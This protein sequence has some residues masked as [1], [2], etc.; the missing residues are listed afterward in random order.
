[1]PREMRLNRRPCRLGCSSTVRAEPARWQA[2]SGP[3][4]SLP[5]RVAEAL[6]GDDG[7]DGRTE[8][9]L[10]GGLCVDSDGLEALQGGHADRLEREVGTDQRA[11]ASRGRHHVGIDG[12]GLARASGERAN[13][14][15]RKR[16]TRRGSVRDLPAHS[17]LWQFGRVQRLTELRAG[18][19]FAGDFRVIRPLAEGGMGVVYV[20]EQLSTGSQRALKLMQRELVQSPQLRERFEREAQLPA[21]I[22]SEHVVKVLGAGVDDSTGLPWFIMELLEGETLDDRV[23]RDPQLSRAELLTIFE[24][25]C[26]ALNAAHREG[27]VHRD[28]KPENVFLAT[29]HGVG[30]AHVAKILDFGIARVVAAAATTSTG[31][32]GTPIYMAPEQ[33]QGRGIRPQTD[34][35]ALGLML[36]YAFTRRTFWRGDESGEHSAASLMYET[37]HAQLPRAS[38]RAQELG[39]HFPSELDDWFAGCV[40]RE[41][42]RRF[43]SAEAAI[44]ALRATITRLS[45]AP[46]SVARTAAALGPPAFAQ[47]QSLPEQPIR[48]PLADDKARSVTPTA[49]ATDVVERPSSAE[50]PRWKAPKAPAKSVGSSVR[51]WIAIAVGGVGAVGA[52]AYGHYASPSAVD[53]GQS[54]AAGPSSDS[55]S[56][57]APDDVAT[58]P[59]DAEKT[60]SGLASKVLVAGSGQAHPNSADAVK[61][62]HTTWTSDGKL[63]NRSAAGEAVSFGVNRV[64]PGLSEGLKLMVVGEK[65]RL[66]IPAKLASGDH[67]VTVDV[68]LRE[69]T[70][71]KPPETPVDVATPPADAKQTASGLAY[72]VLTKGTG[73]EHPGPTSRVQVNYS[74]WTKDGKL[75][76][77]SLT[78]GEFESFGLNRVIPGW[79]EGIQ[80]MVKGEKTRFW[81]PG[82]LAYGDQS[83]RPGAP[84]GQLTFDVELIDFDK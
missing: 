7:R 59:A 20:V 62:R 51:W 2:I 19:L 60:A 39:A 18:T 76:D 25:V 10:G 24:E 43:A 69:I 11:F 68:E 79:T 9:Q 31:V 13:R 53:A 58:P 21:K 34:L 12:Y 64:M 36:F 72:R 47:P 27:I 22:Q 42:D 54:A 1:M 50:I 40:V 83:T 32:M 55:E 77:S 45:A 41:S 35:W 65:R 23:R 14:P 3:P 33:Y 70:P 6:A 4:R 74:G 49:L 66:W 52:W 30:A 78:R 46:P 26:H 75:F 67:Q 73:K 16:S 8:H 71:P 5:T 38:A 81:I 63:F 57:P 37:C 56:T 28:L 17:G 82:K 80:L 44:G 29:R 84:A 48:A 15:C 61:V